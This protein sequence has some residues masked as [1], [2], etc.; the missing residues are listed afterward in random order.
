MILKD[1]S[2]SELSDH[3]STAGIA[4]DFG[5]FRVNLRTDI[6]EL[7]EALTQLYSGFPVETEPAIC[8]F[9]VRIGAPSRLRK[10]IRPK[11]SAYIDNLDPFAPMPRDLAFPL[12][13]STLN[14]CV[15]SDIARYLLLH[16]AVM[17]RNGRAAIFPAPSGTGK[18]TL[19]ALLS[20]AGWRLLSD[21]FAILT[22]EDGRLR[23]SPRPISLK[24]ES[25]DIIAEAGGAGR[26]SRKY[27]GTIKGTLAYLR[28]EG[29]SL[30]EMEQACV[31]A[32]VIF[33]SFKS[34]ASLKVEPM[35][36]SEAF[37]RLIDNAVNYLLLGRTAFLTLT[38]VV[39]RCG[40][41]H[42]EYG[43]SDEAIATLEALLDAGKPP[44]ERVS[45]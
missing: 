13:E 10:F 36:K 30:E 29:P 17:S 8:D 27:E 24:N 6:E 37:M 45:A 7:T 11:V 4:L 26:L 18:S 25:I 23:A 19:S 1:L 34:G 38:S 9:F 32:L 35:E 14:W 31:P 22:A 15:A 42:L 12:F 43:D 2:S 21:E 39:E 28:T 3:L 16:A 20:L 5:S 33:P 44:T 41:Y 40:I